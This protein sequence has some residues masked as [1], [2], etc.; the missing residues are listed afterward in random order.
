MGK[1]IRQGCSLSLYIFMLCVER[2]TH[3]I[4]IAV[5]KGK[6]KPMCVERQGP[7]ISH[8]LFADD[9]LLFVEASIP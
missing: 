8:L 3:L 7:L 9:L 2:L 1:G 5:N 6:W 4:E